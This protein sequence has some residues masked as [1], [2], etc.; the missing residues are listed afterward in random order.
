MVF[1]REVF[2]GGPVDVEEAVAGATIRDVA[3][4]ASHRN[5]CSPHNG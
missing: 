3:H 5:R 2:D 1:E 4:C